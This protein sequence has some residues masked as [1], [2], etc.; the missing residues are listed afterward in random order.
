[1]WSS[2][3][4]GLLLIAFS[5]GVTGGC[6][7]L[8][9]NSVADR[10]EASNLRP[11][12]PQFSQL[13]F[14][15]SNPDGTIQVQNIRNNLYLTEHDFVPRYYDRTIQLRD[16]QGVDFV[17]CPFEKFESLAHT[18]VSFRLADNTYMG[19]SAEI[20]TEP[21]ESFSPLIG[22]SNQFEMTYVVAD[23]RDLIRLRTRHRQA[24][25]YI[26]P[27]VASPEQAQALFLEMMERANQL[28]QKP[29]FYHTLINN[30]TTN[31]RDHINRLQPGRITYNWRLLLPGY[32]AAYAYDQGFLDRTYPFS[33][34]QERGWVNQ[35]AERYYEDP[36]F[37]IKIRQNLR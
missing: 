14:A 36:E 23:E 27:T 4:L 29:E 18:M 35:L 16:I 9:V 31:I 2:K 12:S 37:S 5:L 3:L 17:V 28:A 25:V 34:L 22:L 19:V 33:E 1:M 10:L 20:R 32:S 21:G 30:C 8:Q 7:P 13:P 26:Y 24:D 15:T 11:W 6:R